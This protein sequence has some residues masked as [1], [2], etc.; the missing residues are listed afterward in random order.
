VLTPRG[1]AAARAA[2][3]IRYVMMLRVL[4]LARLLGKV[5]SVAFIA[6]TFL[7]MLPSLSNLLKVLFCIIYVFA[8][9]GVAVFGGSINTDPANPRNA[10]LANSDFGQANYYPNNFN[11]LFSGFVTCFECARGRPTSRTRPHPP[12]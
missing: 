8:A 10:S 6:R 11:D 7:S 4:R 1:R 2:R 5:P 9:L 3:F 12:I